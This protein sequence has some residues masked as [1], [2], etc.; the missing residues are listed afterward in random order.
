MQE[1]SAKFYMK[2]MIPA[3]IS[4]I[5]VGF[6]KACKKTIVYYTH[7]ISRLF[8]NLEIHM[9]K[10]FQSLQQNIYIVAQSLEDCVDQWERTKLSRAF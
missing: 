7:F 5:I 4:R 2:Y 6:L 1:I 9:P 3:L 10:L 8:K